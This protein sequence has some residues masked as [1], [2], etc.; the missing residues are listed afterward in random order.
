MTT[1]A[2]ALRDNAV[3]LGDNGRALCSR[4]RCAG[5][6]ALTTG[7]DLSGQ[8]VSRVTVDDVKAWPAD[9]GPFTCECG[10]VVLS[11]IAGPDGWPLAR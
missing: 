4:P 10:T 8:K 1:T 6:T 9:L 3:Y 11:P 2:S 5:H 7:R